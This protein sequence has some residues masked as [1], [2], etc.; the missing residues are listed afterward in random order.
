MS[1]L[2]GAGGN[3]VSEFIF[4][5]FVFNCKREIEMK[6]TTFFVFVL[7]SIGNSACS[8][9]SVHS[10][11]EKIVTVSEVLNEVKGELNAY[12]ASEPQVKPNIGVC[13]DGKSPMNLTPNKITLSLKTV[14]AQQNEPNAGLTNPIGVLSFDPLYSASYL[15]S[16]AQTL[17]V[18]LNVPKT[19]GIQSVS[20]GDH[21]I[22]SAIAQF[23]DELLKIDHDKTP[24]L[25]YSEKE[26]NS[27]K[28]S[29]A[30]DVVN[31]STGGFS[32]K[33]VPFKFSNKETITDEAHQVLDIEFSLV[34]RHLLDD[35]LTSPDPVILFSPPFRHNSN[36]R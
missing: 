2:E 23:R 14:A 33:L 20:L 8:Y 6:L 9:F 15:Q 7:I 25:Q 11:E 32:L 34:N 22:A 36:F 18:S 16:R 21:P 13:Y 26:K 24:C 29:L 1:V 17:Q 10:S 4:I 28:L 19:N 12:L 31:K 30:F 5:R 3:N 27:L 35:I